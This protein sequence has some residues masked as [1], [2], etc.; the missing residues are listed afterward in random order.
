MIGVRAM[1]VFCDDIREEVQ[2]MHS[3]V[4]IYPD[5]VNVPVVPR[6]MPKLGLYAPE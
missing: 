1:G 5:N 6:M 2:G 3:L 4:G